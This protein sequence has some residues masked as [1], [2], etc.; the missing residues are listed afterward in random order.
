MNGTI[1]FTLGEVSTYY[2]ARVPH[3]KQRRA[4]EW[5]GAF[6]DMMTECHSTR[7]GFHLAGVRRRGPIGILNLA[8]PSA[9]LIRGE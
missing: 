1:Q 4:A 6:A 8:V 9:N 7:G 3:L 2:A 5:R